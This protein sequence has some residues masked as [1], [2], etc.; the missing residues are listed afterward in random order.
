MEDAL[1][2][3]HVALAARRL[4]ESVGVDRRPRMDRRV[5]V[6][7]VPLVRGKLTV[8]MQVLRAEHELELVLG[9]VLVHHGERDDMEGEVPRREPGVLPLVRHRDDVGV[10]HV[11]PMDVAAFGGIATQG[12]DAVVA[13]PAAHV[14]LV[15]LL[16]PEHPGKR[17][18]HDARPILAQ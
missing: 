16:R 14:V 15:G 5:H 12:I 10:E 6:A 9:E 4:V 17:L 13:E 8:R 11:L 2:P 1:E 18:T 7:E 3:V